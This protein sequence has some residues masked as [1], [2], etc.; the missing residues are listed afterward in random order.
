MSFLKW[1][2]SLLSTFRNWVMLITLS[3]QWNGW[4]PRRQAMFWFSI[5]AKMVSMYC[6]PFTSTYFL[7]FK[8][9]STLWI[10][11]PSP[12]LWLLCGLFILFTKWY[13]YSNFDLRKKTRATKVTGI[14]IINKR[15]I[16]FSDNITTLNLNTKMAYVFVP[17][18][19]SQTDYPMA[20]IAN[21]TL[22]RLHK[23]KLS[24]TTITDD[25]KTWTDVACGD[26]ILVRFFFFPFCQNGVN[27]WH[28]PC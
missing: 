26:Q 18:V 24:T 3:K 4:H 12:T 17:C 9:S 10:F 28:L 11:W 21:T 20:N 13:Q 25:V 7:Q 14:I 27:C 15:T 23:K 19:L 2:G 8:F 6:S 5:N 1:K 16:R 22:H